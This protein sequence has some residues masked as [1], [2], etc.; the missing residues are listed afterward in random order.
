MITEA[1]RRS[2][3]EIV[4]KQIPIVELN[5]IVLWEIFNEKLSEARNKNADNSKKLD[6][7]KL[8]KDERMIVS[9]GARELSRQI[10]QAR[11]NF[12]NATSEEEEL[13]IL[14]DLIK[15]EISRSFNAA[16]VGL[17]L[18]FTNRDHMLAKDRFA[19]GT[20]PRSLKVKG[21]LEDLFS[22]HW[23]LDLAVNTSKM[24]RFNNIKRN[25]FLNIIYDFNNKLHL[26]F[27]GVRARARIVLEEE[28]ES[29]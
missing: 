25:A 17:I 11:E 1:K 4:D 19:I 21:E 3:R 12:N 8:L 13:T 23:A 20:L 15:K 2:I 9:L 16:D 24:Y 14:L 18:E 22:A 29:N 6:S 26:A 27:L 5:P 7:K 10:K 28:A